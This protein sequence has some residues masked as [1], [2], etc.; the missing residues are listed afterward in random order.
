VSSGLRCLRGINYTSEVFD[1][2]EQRPEP[3]DRTPCVTTF[4]LLGKLHL[5][6]NLL[7]GSIGLV[8]FNGR[9]LE[10]LKARTG[11]QEQGSYLRVAMKSSRVIAAMV[12]VWRVPLEPSCIASLDIVSLLGAS[13]IFTKS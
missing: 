11:W 12:M 6:M 1:K 10:K 9:Q 8:L 4:Q 7:R 13:R 2:P 5:K 3:Q